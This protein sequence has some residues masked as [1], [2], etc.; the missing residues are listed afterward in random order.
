MSLFVP[1][2]FPEANWHWPVSG[3]CPPP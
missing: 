1:L 2:T 3:F